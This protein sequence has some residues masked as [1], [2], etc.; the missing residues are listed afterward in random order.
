MLQQR[1][2]SDIFCLH[3]R[4]QIQKIHIVGFDLCEISGNKQI[5]RDMEDQW[6]PRAGGGH[7]D[8]P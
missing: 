4:N 1:W 6:L 3:D 7:K 8:S 2:S 5:C